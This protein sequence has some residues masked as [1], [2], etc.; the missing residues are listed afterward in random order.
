MHAQPTS[1]HVN[2]HTARTAA[3]MHATQRTHAPPPPATRRLLPLRPFH[4][5]TH[6]QGYLQFEVMETAWQVRDQ[7]PAVAGGRGK[8]WKGR[9]V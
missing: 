9:G 2:A 1:T 8:K 4:L 7:G 3:G 5:V 6:P